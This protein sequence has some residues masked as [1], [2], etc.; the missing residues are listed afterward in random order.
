MPTAL[1]ADAGNGANHSSSFHRPGRPSLG[2]FQGSDGWWHHQVRDGLRLAQWKHAASRREDMEGLGCD[3]GID[4]RA[5]LSLYRSKGLPACRR[6]LLRGILAGSIRAGRRLHQA[7]LADS[8]HCAF[9]GSDSETV[10]HMWWHCRAWEHIRV[11][12]D[13][14]PLS[15]TSTWPRCTRSCG[16]FLNDAEASR[17]QARE[18]QEEGH[19]ESPAAAERRRWAVGCHNMFLEILTARKA[20]E[21]SEQAEAP[22]D[23]EEQLQDAAWLLAAESDL[24]VVRERARGPGA[25]NPG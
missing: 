6:G 21:E 10:E 19:V 7:G 23:E 8:S 4:R 20:A 17:A 1:A 9:C 18:D 22:D 15:V 25:P 24:P 3:E 12:A 14:P 5:T 11:R 16:I 2:L 13:V